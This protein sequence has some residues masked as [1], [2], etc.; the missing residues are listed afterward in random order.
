MVT[1]TSLHLCYVSLAS[2]SAFTFMFMFVCIVAM[3]Q[4]DE[5]KKNREEVE[6][7]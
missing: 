4:S 2:V 6:S 5:S 1:A 7:K 3:V